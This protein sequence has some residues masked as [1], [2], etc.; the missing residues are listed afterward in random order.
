M[1]QEDKDDTTRVG[2]WITFGVV[3]LVVISTVSAMVVRQL[4]SI[5]APAPAAAVVAPAAVLLVEE[6]VLIEAPLA[7]D[8]AAT[9]YF[10]T[11]ESALPAEAAPAIAAVAQALAAAPARKIVLSGFHDE[12]GDAA[13]NAELAKQRALSVRAALVAAGID[14]SRIALRKPEIS[15]G[16]GSDQEARRVELR[17]VD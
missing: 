17:L 14:A 2:L 5:E 16:S 12:T 8:L 4:Q 10:G 9:L 13:R 3:A 7:G 15:T 11:G 6:I 1:Y